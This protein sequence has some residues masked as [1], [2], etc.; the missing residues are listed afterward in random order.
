M[1]ETAD[2]KGAG[3]SGREFVPN[4]DGVTGAKAVAAPIITAAPS[5]FTDRTILRILMEE[6]KMNGA[7]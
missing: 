5:I 3:E 6:C 4:E 7:G 1:A 2:F